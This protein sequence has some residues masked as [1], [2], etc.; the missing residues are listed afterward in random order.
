MGIKAIIAAQQIPNQWLTTLQESY[1]HEKLR[2]QVWLWKNLKKRP[3]MATGLVGWLICSAAS[4][5]D[6]ANQAACNPIVL[7]TPKPIKA[8]ILLG[9]EAFKPYQQRAI[10]P[11]WPK[12][13]GKWLFE[14][15]ACQTRWLAE[16]GARPHHP[17]AYVHVQKCT[18]LGS[19]NVGPAHSLFGLLAWVQAFQTRPISPQITSSNNLVIN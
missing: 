2:V 6:H 5:S 16:P 1:T 12:R 11:A 10:T 8:G 19:M 7:Q 13:S 3:E 18:C 9:Y 14:L 15:H 4:R 17:M